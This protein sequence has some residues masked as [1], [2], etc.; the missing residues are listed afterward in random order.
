MPGSGTTHSL[1]DLTRLSI[2]WERRLRAANLS[3][4]PCQ[5]HLEAF[6]IHET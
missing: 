1:G 6:L 5:P 2:S 3:P 4:G